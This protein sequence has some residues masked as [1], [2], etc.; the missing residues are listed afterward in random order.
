MGGTGC[1]L[2]SMHSTHNIDILTAVTMVSD[3]TGRAPRG[4]IHRRVYQMNPWVKHLGMVPGDRATAV[5]FLSDG[6]IAACLPGGGEEAMQGHES[7]Y[8]LGERWKD[9]R[10]YAHVAKE[11]GVRIYPC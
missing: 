8:I 2:V 4:L 6:Y 9:R 7:A 5:K 10:G 3:K 1:L 11:A